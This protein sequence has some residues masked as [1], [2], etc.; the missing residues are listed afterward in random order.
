MNRKTWVLA[1]SSHCA[2][3]DVNASIFHSKLRPFKSG[4]YLLEYSS[5]SMGS[6]EATFANEIFCSTTRPSAGHMSNDTQAQIAGPRARTKTFCPVPFGAP[7][8]ESKALGPVSTAAVDP[9]TALDGGASSNAAPSCAGVALQL[10]QFHPAPVRWVP[11]EEVAWMDGAVAISSLFVLTKL[12]T[13]GATPADPRGGTLCF[14][15]VSLPF[16]LLLPPSS[17]Q[18]FPIDHGNFW[19]IW[20]QFVQDVRIRCLTKSILHNRLAWQFHWDVGN[21]RKDWASNWIQAN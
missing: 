8:F 11:R 10:L 18:H 7:A 2:D 6:K 21:T 5:K 4:P 14:A 1:A 19:C 16:S 12:A 3:F 15:P 20:G 9:G 17:K 13:S